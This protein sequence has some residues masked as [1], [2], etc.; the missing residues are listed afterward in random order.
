MFKKKIQNRKG[1]TSIELMI[2]TMIASIIVIGVGMTIADSHRGYDAMYDRV[3]SD[4]VS[5]AYVARRTF[6]NVIRRATRTRF[7]LDAN[8]NWLEAYYCQD[9]NATIVDS[10]ARFSEDIT[11]GTLNVEYGRLN[12]RETLSTNTVCGNVDGCIFFKGAGYSAQMVLTLDNGS[13]RITVVS[14]AVMHNQ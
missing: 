6:D 12:P 1:F 2:A 13:E 7:L 10:Y 3:Y 9:P 5:D 4:V 14:S 11:T 8:G